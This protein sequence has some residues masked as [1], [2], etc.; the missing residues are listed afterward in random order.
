VVVSSTSG[1][2]SILGDEIDLD[3]D[4]NALSTSGAL[5]FSPLSE[6][7]SNTFELKGI[8]ISTTS[9]A[10]TLGKSGN[11]A[12]ITI[13]DAIS[14]AGPINIYADMINLDADLTTTN[15]GDILLNTDNALGGLEESIAVTAAGTFKYI[16]N[17]TSFVTDITYP[18]KNLALTSKGLTIGSATNNK[19]IIIEEDVTSQENIELLGKDIFINT[20]L[21]LPILQI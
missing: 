12:N 14:V 4:G 17:G 21:K 10:L 7:F 3:A 1:D 6:S 8:D 9:S 2:I 18:I 16:P 19:D 15:N 11:T 5:S 20:N 13:S